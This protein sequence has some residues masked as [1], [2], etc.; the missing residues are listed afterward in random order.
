[1]A[2]QTFKSPG[3][4]DTEIVTERNQNLEKIIT[5]VPAGIIGYCQK[6]PAFTPVT[7]HSYER[8]VEIFGEAKPEYPSAL[9]AKKFLENRDALTFVRVLGAGANTT[10]GHFTTTE[11]LGIVQN[12][13]FALT[14]SG[15]P[16]S[17]KYEDGLVQFICAKHTVSNLE[18]NGY[19]VFTY[20]NTVLSN[21][22]RLVR[23]VLFTTSGSRFTTID[24]GSEFNP[25]SNDDFNAS[26]VSATT[27]DAM[28]DKFK[29][30]LTSS[31]SS[32][33][34]VDGFNG[35]KV[36]TASLNPTD[37]AYLSKVLNTDPK[38]FQIDQ[39]LLYMHFPV[40]DEIAE[41][42]KSSAIAA[43]VGI[44]SGSANQSNESNYNFNNIF[45]NY[46]SRYT[47]PKTTDFISQPFGT[48]EYDLFH[49][50]CIDEG[51][52]ANDMYKISISNIK[53]SDDEENP[54]STFN[55]ELRLK[56]DIDTS[57][58]I[59]E[60]Y[61]NCDLNPKS[62]NYIAN[63]IGDMKIIYN[64][65]AAEESE[66]RL[67]IK[68]T[69]PNKSGRIRIVMNDNVVSEIIPKDAV[70][71]GFRGLPLI[72][73]NNAAPATDDLDSVVSDLR[74]GG[75]TLYENG[76][77]TELLGSVL[78]PVPMRFKLTTGEYNSSPA[79]VGDASLKEGV[80]DFLYWG[81]K[82][83][84]VPTAAELTNP[85]TRANES[86]VYNDIMDNFSKFMG[87]SKLDAVLTG[88]GCDEFHHNKF[89][90]SKVGLGK[91][92]ESGESLANYTP[93]L[94]GSIKSLIKDTA[95]FRNASFNTS[96]YTI[97]DTSK[98]AGGE[99]RLSFASLLSLTSSQYFNRF[100]RYAKFTNMFYGGFDGVNILDKDMFYMNDKASSN[101]S[102]G[103]GVNSPDIGLNM[104]FG[105]G[106]SN[107]YVHSYKES[108]NIITDKN[109]S[110]INI[111]A[112]PG[113]R[114]DALIDHTIEKVED[115]GK[116]LYLIDI[117]SYDSSGNR[118][119]SDS[120]ANINV[121]NSTE[122][123]LGKNYDSSYAAAY[124]PDIVVEDNGKRS[125][126][127]STIAAL[128]AISYN[129]STS[130]PWFAPAGFNRGSLGFVKGSKIKLNKAQRDDV[131]EA[132][133]NPIASFPKAGYVIF[134]QKTLQRANTSLD[135]INVRRMLLDLKRIASDI[136][137]TFTFESNNAET[138]SKFK[139]MLDEK[140][141][142]IQSGQGIERFET[143]INSTNNTQSD[144]DNNVM[145][146]RIVV[147][148][149]RTVEFI[150]IDFIVSNSGIDFV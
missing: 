36:F 45:G 7:V 11:Q 102:G 10:A 141:S 33:G 92:I 51:S 17:G 91:F 42:D 133:I 46:N 134:G 86:E 111:L 94:T 127:P 115:Y 9:A 48:I 22:P 34:T 87:I 61:I 83:E 148:P 6:G 99:Y 27:T 64:F 55:V 145:N 50:E 124:F 130:H 38:R 113:I 76:S 15:A 20:N 96:D 79:F 14:S 125:H 68:G 5:T 143:I 101:D 121:R 16:E 126:A 98:T 72:K 128:S 89:T 90:L 67:I 63:K 65:D 132:R 147:I 47:A 135:R 53:K 137:L 66:R 118:L 73:T 1:M 2:E 78:P 12:A 112:I 3:F 122:E 93:L 54:Y 107:Q 62:E 4:Y 100:S 109:Q 44:F 150:A 75:E 95:Y 108:V 120:A 116:A 19:P 32:L 106:D 60:Q 123:F 43:V 24:F 40:E 31:D 84:R 104:S 35:A 149:T 117:P 8:F 41:L 18:S 25:S 144:I 52:Y 21:T 69:F 59:V 26:Y 49:F 142:E 13:G 146:G 131:Y 119:Y 39:H 37:D 138:R 139:K 77:G 97:R 85:I 103:K 136:A 88:S 30:I 23:G 28:Y 56:R 140:I 58:N 110:R 29:L 80:S 82:F 71:F 57:P 74:F 129:D 81:M 114:S 105:T 70:P